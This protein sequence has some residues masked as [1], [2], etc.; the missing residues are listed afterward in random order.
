[1][2]KKRLMVLLNNAMDMLEE[3]GI[4]NLKE[5]LG[6]NEDEFNAIRDN[7]D[8]EMNAGYVITD[9][10]QLD[11]GFGVVLGHK[12]NAMPGYEYVTWIQN[13]RGYDAGYYFS[14]K[15]RAIESLL[16][17]S[18]ILRGVNLR[19]KYLNEYAEGDI[20]A[21]LMEFLGTEEASLFLR[22][23]NF[24]GGALDTYYDMDHSYENEAL[25]EALESLYQ[26]KVVNGEIMTADFKQFTYNKQCHVVLSDGCELTGKMMFDK[27]HF[28][29]DNE[30]EG[31]ISDVKSIQDISQIIINDETVYEKGKNQ[32]C[33]EMNIDYKDKDNDI[34][35][36]MYTTDL[37]SGKRKMIDRI[38]E[39]ASENKINGD[40]NCE[41]TIEKNG[42]YLD[43][44]EVGGEVH[45]ENDNIIVYIDDIELSPLDTQIKNAL[46]IK[47]EKI[48]KT[49]KYLVF[50]RIRD[51]LNK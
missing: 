21:A 41:F 35:I 34:E 7:D 28:V 51:E 10:F 5:E 20:K 45:L 46:D 16:D 24:I 31:L 19:D 13:V 6:M 22:N 15:K 43:H 47:D 40:I 23:K 26:E 9:K 39:I 17:R 14:D 48:N 38:P 8:V 44:D 1:M 4:E 27:D 18:A 36:E 25:R 12:E 33:I 11:D 30:E 32:Y 29:V 37:E 50:D 2:E 3:Q 49:T 42:I